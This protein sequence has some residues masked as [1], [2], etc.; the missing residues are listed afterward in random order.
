MSDELHNHDEPALPTVFGYSMQVYQ[1]MLEEASMEAL[2]P[3][4]GDEQGLVYDGFATKLIQN[5]DLPV[6]YYTKVFRELKRM[7]CVRQLRRGGSTTTSRWL[8]LQEPTPELFREM[9]EDRTP[10]AK[11]SVEQ[12]INDLNNRMGRVEEVLGL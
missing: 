7:D 10:G 6:P 2:G 1:A 8:L 11:D 5:L 3:E 12:R 4:Y 9:P